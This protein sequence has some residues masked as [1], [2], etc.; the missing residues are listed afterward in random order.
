[1]SILRSSR[2]KMYDIAV[3]LAAASLLV[4]FKCQNLHGPHPR[5]IL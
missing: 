1:M 5:A 4:N 3:P 2:I